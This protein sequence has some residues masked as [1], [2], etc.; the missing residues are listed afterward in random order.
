MSVT[1]IGAAVRRKEDHRFITGQGRYT[2]V[3]TRRNGRWLAVAAHVT[4]C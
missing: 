1:G 3:W 4:R 2:D